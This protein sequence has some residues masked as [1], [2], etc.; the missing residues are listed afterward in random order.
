MVRVWTDVVHYAGDVVIHAGG[1]YQAIKDTARRPGH[2]DWL[3]LAAPGTSGTDGRNG[4]NGRDAKSF[5]ICGTYDPDCVGGKPGFLK[6]E[7]L[8]VVTLNSTW[9]VARKDNPG[10]CPGP[11]WQSGPVGR[12]GEKGERGQRGDP[13]VRGPSGTDGRE[14][15]GWKV[16]RST[17]TITPVMSDGEMGPDVAVRDL[18]DEFGNGWEIR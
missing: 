13:G 7:A 9:F 11:D 10:A 3:C 18:F 5:R 2:S 15:V 16:D 6:Y 4:T 17:F 1:T 12:R 14:I 8:D